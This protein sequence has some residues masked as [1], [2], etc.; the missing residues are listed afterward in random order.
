VAVVWFEVDGQKFDYRNGPEEWHKLVWPGQGK[1]LGASLRVRGVD[2]Q[3]ETVQQDGEWGLFRLL[4][5][6]RLKGAPGFRDFTMTWSLPGL[7]VV[8]TVDFRPARSDSPFFGVQRGGKA[9]LLAPFRS[10]MVVPLGIGKGSP[11]CN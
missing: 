11:A 8:M 10:G 2:G 5:A 1:T 7:G 3:E 4:E 9:R 6:G